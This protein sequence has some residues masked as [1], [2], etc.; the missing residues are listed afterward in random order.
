MGFSNLTSFLKTVKDVEEN[1]VRKAIKASNEETVTILNKSSVQ[2]STLNN[3]NTGYTSKEREDFIK[4]ATLESI[5][6]NE[7]RINSALDS[8]FESSN[9]DKEREEFWVNKLC[10]FFN[11]PKDLR[12]EDKKVLIDK[13]I[14]ENSE[15][16]EFVQ[17]LLEGDSRIR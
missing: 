8:L 13:A 6:N 5:K 7:A 1:K 16:L 15:T 4:A 2:L 12:F 10:I 17:F 3:N 9:I 14:Y 11:I